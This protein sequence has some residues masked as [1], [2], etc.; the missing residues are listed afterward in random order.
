MNKRGQ[1][2]IL[3]TVL[4]VLVGL[5]AV[6]ILAVFI[7][8]LVR[9]NSQIENNKVELSIDYVGTFYDT[10]NTEAGGCIVVNP[11]DCQSQVIY[12]KINSN[13]NNSKLSA[14]KLVFNIDGNSVI[15]TT[16]DVPN[17]FESRTYKYLAQKPDFVE[18]VPVINISGKEKSLVVV[19]KFDIKA[20]NK[21]M[22]I[23]DPKIVSLDSC[24]SSGLPEEKLKIKS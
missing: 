8:N 2:N 3:T 20:I 6:T 16:S 12:V 15:C 17:M 7:I 4:L 18:I 23:L 5:V 21:S 9:Q 22:N 19:D 11:G 24:S 1:S 13:T 10:T 14:L